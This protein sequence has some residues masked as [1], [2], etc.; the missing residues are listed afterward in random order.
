M[1]RFATPAAT[2]ALLAIYASY[3]GTTITFEYELPSVETFRE[4]IETISQRYPYLLWEEGGKP[5]GYAY[6]HPFHERAAYQWSAELS[7][8][9]AP[10]ARGRGLGRRLYAA[11]TELL[12]LQGVRTAY[13]LVTCPNEP[14]DRFHRAMGFSAIGAAHSAGYKNGGW[15]SVT[16][17]EKPLQPYDGAPAPLKSIR[18]VDPGTV[19]AVL[20]RRSGPGAS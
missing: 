1:L 20:A 18:D 17:Y 19:A 8:Y 6:A 10:D 16:F 11:L 3:I 2:E 9:L 5:L 12:T 7:V 15:H 13:A 14:S 4:R